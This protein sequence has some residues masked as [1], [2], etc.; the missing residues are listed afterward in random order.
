MSL[1]S[2]VAISQVTSGLLDAALIFRS[3][4]SE[5]LNEVILHT[6]Q[7]QIAVGSKN[8]ILKSSPKDFINEI[9]KVPAIT[10]RSS[11]GGNLW[12]KHP[13]FKTAGIIPKHTY[14]YEDTQTA[15]QL[16]SQTNGW[17]F[18]PDVILKTHKSIKK[19]VLLEKLSAPV[20][21]SM[22]LKRSHRST[23]LI[24]KLNAVIKTR[25]SD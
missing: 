18:M 22:I 4:Y 13:A 25:L 19:I 23:Q 20:N 2:G 16:L 24:E 6:G 8:P 11:A 21:I 12:E 1:D 5:S 14:F 3:S 10:F 7:F 15:L 9:N 17:A